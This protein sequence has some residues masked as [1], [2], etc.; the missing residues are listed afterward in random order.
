MKNR[1]FAVK[2]ITLLFAIV[3]GFSTARADNGTWLQT[4]A[5]PFDWGT[6]G[7]WSDAI[8]DG[9]DNTAFF[10]SSLAAAQTVNLDAARTIGNIT[11]STGGDRVRTISGANTLTLATSS[12]TPTI[13]VATSR[14]L[15]IGTDIAGTDGLQKTGA[16]SLILTGANSFSGGIYC[17]GGTLTIPGGGGVSLGDSGNIVTFTGDSTFAQSGNTGT[18]LSQGFVVNEGVTATLSGGHPA[19]ITI[20]NSVT[21]SGTLKIRGNGKLTCD[22]KGTNGV[23]SGDIILGAGGIN[24]GTLIMNNSLADA[25]ESRVKM[26]ELEG[27]GAF[28]YGTGAVVPLVLS[29]RQ[30]ELTGTTGG[31]TF[32]NDATNVNATVTINT[33]LLITG[34]G[35]KTFTLGGTHTGKN[36]FAGAITNGAASVISL[37]KADAGTWIVS[38]TNNSYTGA[39]TISVGTLSINTIA[40]FA[41][42]SSIGKG[43]SG[44]AIVLGSS[45]STGT[46]DYRGAAAESDRTIQINSWVNASTGGARIL[47]NGTGALTFDAATFNVAYANANSI[48][49]LLTLGGTSGGTI[50][51]VIQDNSATCLVGFSKVGSGTWT[52]GGVNTYTGNTDVNAGTLRLQSG[53]TTITQTQGGLRNQSADGTLISN[54]SGAGDLS[55]TF[56]SYARAAGATG[57]IVSTGGIN[58]TDNSVNITGAAGFIDKGL[59]FGGSEFAA[60]NALNGYVRALNYATT[61]GDANTVPI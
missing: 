16:G 28:T 15:T 49:R 3:C 37:T 12:G 38:N 8:A 53:A 9:E 29:Q 34:V 54:K 39:T 11:A 6:A 43:T 20:N 60:R 17:G 57:N 50:T 26:G 46:L 27:S 13:D 36:T 30:I 44:T 48:T 59:Y 51:G 45:S 33:D 25:P 2:W 23:F 18:T 40:D 19:V 58:G 7:N 55:T 42:D 31:G 35:D 41:E 14:T 52:L 47:N 1:L 5:G 24:T 22:F 21:G 56:S 32:N 4:A 10:T 61:G